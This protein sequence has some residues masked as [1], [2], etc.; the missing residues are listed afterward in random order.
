[1]HPRPSHSRGTSHARWAPAHVACT[2]VT[3]TSPSRTQTPHAPTSIQRAHTP[4]AHLL[5]HPRPLHPHLSHA[6]KPVGPPVARTPVTHANPSCTHARGHPS[7]MRTRHA[8]AY[9]SR[10]TLASLAHLHPLPP[11]ACCTPPVARTPVAPTH[12]ART[13]PSRTHSPCACTSLHLSY[14]RKP[15]AHTYSCGANAG[16]R[17]VA[18][19]APQPCPS[20]PLGVHANPSHG[21]LLRTHAHHHPLTNSTPRPPAAPASLMPRS[22]V[23]ASVKWSHWLRWRLQLDVATRRRR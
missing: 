3:H 2:L 11:A 13:N 21:H 14:P 6:C 5:A 9:S 20:Q 12:V 7:R 18:L 15:V 10:S 22:P 8:H 4:R 16:C 23:G 19:L 17:H 1:M